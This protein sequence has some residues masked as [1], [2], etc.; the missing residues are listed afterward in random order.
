MSD[1][2]EAQIQAAENVYPGKRNFFP[3]VLF[4]QLQLPTH[5]L[6]ALAT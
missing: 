4:L 3:P 5:C 6:C 1:F 2:C